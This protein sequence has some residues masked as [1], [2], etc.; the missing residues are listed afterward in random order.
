MS[1]DTVAFRIERDRL[2]QRL[3]RIEVV[4]SALRERAV[5]RHTVLGTTP[6]PLRDAIR[7]F[8]LE[9]RDLRRRLGRIRGS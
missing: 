4:T 1:E 9:I 7:S 8:E 3:R 6:A 2:Q 5:Y